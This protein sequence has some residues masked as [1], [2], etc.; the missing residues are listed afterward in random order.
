MPVVLKRPPPP[1][2]VKRG[3]WEPYAIPGIDV[4]L[5]RYS[6]A[7]HS[8][9]PHV[10]AYYRFREPLVR[11]VAW[12]VWPHDGGAPT[13]ML[14]TG[15]KGSG[16][17]SLIMQIAAHCN[18]PVFRININVGTTVR[19]LKGHGGVAHGATVFHDGIATSAME[20]GGWLL[21]DELSGAT[22]PVALSLFPVLE[23]DGAVL[24]EDAEPPRYVSRH[25]DFRV[26]ATD[27]AIGAE[28]EESRFSYAGTN[29]DQNEAL[30]DR[31]GSTIHVEYL[32]P[33]EEFGF[34][35]SKVPD[36]DVSDLEAILRIARNVRE[37]KS[38]GATISMRTTW[39]WARRVAAGK[40]HATGATMKAARSD[41]AVF[42]AAFPTFLAKL[43]SVA[44]R[45]VIVEVMRR[46]LDVENK[47]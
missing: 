2:P 25:S 45:D 9:V 33:D 38:I 29:P 44:E 35:L 5:Y 17:T 10:D 12:S 31:F 34:I 11:E 32:A 16:K 30:L 26:F 19:H 14:I 43:R 8:L 46:I 13:P 47:K 22:P 23:T 40:V 41:V 6:G 4:R 42:E 36:I 21:L 28:M 15:P 7:R 20:V 37:T 24:L 1:S 27:N 39:Q 18:V 3:E